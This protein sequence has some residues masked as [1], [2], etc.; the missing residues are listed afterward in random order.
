MKITP[1]ILSIPPFVSTK[2]SN[3][4]AIRVR[5]GIDSPLLI[6]TLN[7]GSQTE[8]PDLEQRQIDEIFQ[9]HAH[10]SSKDASAPKT[11][12]LFDSSLSLSLPIKPDGVMIDPLSTQLQH[13]PAQSKLPPLPPQ[14][15]DKIRTIVSS[16]GIE[17]LPFF[18]KAEPDCNCIYCQLVRSFHGEEELVDDRDLTF[19]DWEVSQI[20]EKLYRVINPLDNNERYD[21]FLGDPLGCTC[22]EK[23]CEHIRA[24]LNT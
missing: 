14:I 18:E 24:V 21:V 2:W 15:L 6:I 12:G 23:T 7:D 20:E 13:N 5:K 19:R 10:F 22:G 11:N 8:I 3:I 9:A 1:E 17:E 4:V 16:L